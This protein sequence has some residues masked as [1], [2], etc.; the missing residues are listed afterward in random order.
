MKNFCSSKNVIK[1]KKSEGPEAVEETVAAHIQNKGL[2][3]D[4]NKELLKINR[5]KYQAIQ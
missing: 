5:K 3:Q 4:W 1:S 2:T